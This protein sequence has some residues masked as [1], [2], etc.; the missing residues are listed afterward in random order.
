M[1]LYYLV[2]IP[3]SKLSFRVIYRISN[4]LYFFIYKCFEYRKKV[5]LNNLKKTYNY[6]SKSEIQEIT[7]RFY[8]HLCDLIVESIKGFS[9]TEEQ[10]K[11]RVVYKNAKLID[12]LI[13]QGKSVIYTGGHYNN[14]EWAALATPLAIKA[15]VYA[16]YTPLKNAFINQKLKASRSRTG[17]KFISSKEVKEIFETRKQKPFVMVFLTDQS[18]SNPAKAYFTEFLGR[19]TPVLFGAEKYAKTYDCALVYGEMTKQERGRYQLEVKVL[20]DD[21]S[22]LLKGEATQ[23]H[24]KAI[25]QSIEQ[26]PAY[27]LWTHRRWKH[28]HYSEPKSASQ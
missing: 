2:I 6:K 11:K 18:P 12:Q 1:I 16:I 8:K 7:Q 19:K 5:V 13:E 26:D 23:L 9:I 25:E 15:D 21:V 22:D 20:S 3:L 14:W 10:L 27:W 24:V 17:I 4:I 28:E